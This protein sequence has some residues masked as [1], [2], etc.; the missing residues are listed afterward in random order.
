MGPKSDAE[1]ASFLRE[2]EEKAAQEAAA[3]APE[4]WR[5]NR[6]GWGDWRGPTSQPEVDPAAEPDSS[7]R[8][9]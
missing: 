3:P 9:D 1:I 7:E 5:W 6:T 8:K 2:R 4:G